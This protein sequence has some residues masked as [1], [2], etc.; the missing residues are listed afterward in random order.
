LYLISFPYIPLSK[1]GGGEALYSVV[2]NFLELLGSSE[3]ELIEFNADDTRTAIAVLYYRVILVDGRIR[4]EELDHYRK[5]LGESLS[6]S[7]DEL[8][9][10]EKTV[11][12]EI[13]NERSLFPFT[14]IVRKLP[15][16]KRR[17]ILEHMHQISLSDKELHEFEINLVERTAELL[18]IDGWQEKSPKTAN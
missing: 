4:S 13:K 1:Q 2:K 16:E 11:L 14:V 7:E 15:K 17:E 12:E 8:L 6:V 10:F 5:I 18:N 9:L 3:D